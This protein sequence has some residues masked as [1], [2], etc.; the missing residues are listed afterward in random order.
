M[1]AFPKVPF[2]EKCV[3]LILALLLTACFDADKTIRNSNLPGATPMN[4]YSLAR[5]D[6]S[7]PSEFELI[8]RQQSLSRVQA[9]TFPINDKTLEQ[10]W[11]EHVD[12]IR[13]D[14]ISKE[15]PTDTITTG[16]ISSGFPIVFYF[17][18]SAV[19]HRV[20]AEAYRLVGKDILRLKFTGTKGKEDNIKHLFTIISNDYR[21]EIPNGFNLGAGSIIGEASV[22]E[23]STVSLKNVETQCHLTIYTQTA[24]S[25]L[26]TGPTDNIE[27]EIEGL[28]EEGIKLEMLQQQ[29]KA[30]AGLGGEEAIISIEDPD[31]NTTML[32]Y[33]WFYA[34]ET[35]NAFK[36]EILVKMSCPRSEQKQAEEIWSELIDS[37]KVRNQ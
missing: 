2:F 5:L 14:Q 26:N 19:P 13:K 6:Y 22:N 37:L 16:E 21:S 9:A 34:G 15:L 10:I 12:Q 36:P 3:V 18:N 28:S 4:Q 1:S 31:S 25:N 11:R 8:G 30:V 23:G 27:E 24:G 17:A 35:T 32:R 20:T 7:L 33:T 29:E